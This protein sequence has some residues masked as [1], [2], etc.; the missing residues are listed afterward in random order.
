VCTIALANAQGVLP[1][2]VR[3]VYIDG[4]TQTGAT[5][6][7]LNL[8]AG[9]DADLKIVLSGANLGAGSIGLYFGPGSHNSSVQGLVINNFQGS[10]IRL[11]NDGI[12][13]VAGNFIGTDATGM[14]AAPNGNGV[15][16]VEGLGSEIGGDNPG[17]RNV[18]SGN[19]GDGISIS[20]DFSG[21]ISVEG[22]YI[23]TRKDG[24]SALANNIG[25]N[26]F[27]FTG[28]NV[29]GC[30]IENGDNVISGNTAA[31]IRMTESAFNLVQGNRIGTDKAGALAVP[32]GIGVD[33]SDAP[34]NAI[35]A[36]GFG[37][38]I[39]GNT[40][41]G[42]RIK[43]TVDS[44]DPSSDNVIYGN[45]IGTN[46]QGL[47]AIPNDAGILIQ[48]S[49]FNDI[50]SG[51][52]LD[53]NLISG[54]THEG[55]KLENSDLI[56]VW[57]NFIGTDVT[58]SVAVP[59][60]A[61]VEISGGTGNEIGCTFPGSGNVIS[62]NLGG[63]VEITGSANG[64]FVQNNLIGLQVDGTSPLGNGSVGVEIYVGATNNIVGVE[65]DGGTT[66]T[67][68]DSA[69]KATAGSN[70][71]TATAAGGGGCSKRGTS[72]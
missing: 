14:A 26:L 38:L 9:D 6:N 48:D 18:I 66:R 68:R 64:N 22:N 27:G 59:N 10:G 51:D 1:Q 45:K 39:S 72:H 3:Q 32:N 2:I 35:G 49:P 30:E 11:E 37:N 57:G 33:L 23:G 41:A 15:A 7:T 50:G 63:G 69:A 36:D 55:I 58:G 54:N 13:L 29:I 8:S 28:A 17:A 60:G 40:G 44:S 42:V 52:A 65:S 4:Y 46:F 53:R 70:A 5:R 24:G 19:T 62:G 21:F 34:F 47:A 61:G 12:N 56:G 25:V 43:T 20:G 31:G 67:T 16:V 71:R